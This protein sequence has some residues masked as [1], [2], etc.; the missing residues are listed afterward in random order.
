MSLLNMQDVAKQSRHVVLVLTRNW[1]SSEWA[2]FEVLVGG[3]KD[4]AGL[5]KKLILCYVKQESKKIFMI[6]FPCEPG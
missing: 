5:Q 6:L 4:P 3:T 2:F 1:L